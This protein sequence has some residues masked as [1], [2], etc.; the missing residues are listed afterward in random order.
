MEKTTT[1]FISGMTFSLTDSAYDKLVSYLGTL[2][3]HFANE[4]NSDEIMR[5]IESRIAEKLTEKKDRIIVETDVED[6][7]TEIG[8]P[9]Q[10]ETDEKLASKESPTNAKGPKKLY[11]NMDDAWFGGV[12]SGIAAY[13]HVDPLW[14]RLAFLVAAFLYGASVILYV[15][16]WI[17]IP[18]AKSASQK[19]E[20]RGDYVNLEN[21]TR[22]FKERVKEVQE[23]GVIKK[24]FGSMRRVT[25]G[26]FRSSKSR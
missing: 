21:I 12:A 7:I 8:R 3:N 9:S 22:A 25:R 17:L 19:L 23:R 18:E 6:I 24:F 4:T 14:V 2:K 10:F 11:R 5:D 1:I 26:L 20:M 15:I 13:F 16:F